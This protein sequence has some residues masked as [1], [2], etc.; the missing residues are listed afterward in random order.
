MAMETQARRWSWRAVG[1]GYAA[2]F[3]T[4]KVAQFGREMASSPDTPWGPFLDTA[5]KW[6][7]LPL[8]FALA[9][10]VPIAERAAQR[11]PIRGDGPFALGALWLA[12]WPLVPGLGFPLPQSVPPELVRAQALL[13]FVVVGVTSFVAFEN[14]A[15]VARAK[16]SLAW[17]RRAW[18]TRSPSR[19]VQETLQRIVAAAPQ[20]PA[21]A[22]REASLLAQ[23]LQAA[24]L[25]L[26]ASER[27]LQAELA[28]LE[29][30]LELQR[31]RFAGRA[32]IT[33]EAAPAVEKAR[34][35]DA[36]LLPLVEHTIERAIAPRG[37][38]SL[39]IAVRPDGRWLVLEI[40]DDGPPPPSEGEPKDVES[41]PAAT[42]RQARELAVPEAWLE[43][44][45]NE[46]GGTTTWV[47][48]PLAFVGQAA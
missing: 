3:V 35:P 18:R 40:A 32:V 45:R 23:W 26:P 17:H 6:A 30:F 11:Q 8:V 10:L 1:Y 19:T 4:G 44:R 28:M 22:Q 15:A 47:R 29:P 9:I 20:D 21:A 14:Y 41:V 12:V 5:V 25:E 37:A 48:V 13:P 43:L 24:A 31:L 36:L 7:C 34:M 42:I 16:S 27:T 39:R 38:G 46:R 33:V 2:V